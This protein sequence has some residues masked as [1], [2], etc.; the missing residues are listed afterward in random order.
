MNA[1]GSGKVLV[2]YATK[3][4]STEEIAEAITVAYGR[5]VT[6]SKRAR[7]RM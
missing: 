5:R 6:M 1:N 7:P 4:G 3:H 2:A